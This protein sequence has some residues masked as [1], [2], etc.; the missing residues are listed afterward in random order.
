VIR[1]H[2]TFLLVGCSILQGGCQPDSPSAHN[3]AAGPLAAFLD[4]ED[5]WTFK[6]SVNVDS[7][8]PKL[9]EPYFAPE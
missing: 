8:E 3:E 6:V 2:F 4:T 9:D 7:T 1:L 5:R